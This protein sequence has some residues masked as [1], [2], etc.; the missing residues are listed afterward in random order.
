MWGAKSQPSVVDEALGHGKVFSAEG[1]PKQQDFR[2][3]AFIFLL[4]VLIAV[5]ELFKNRGFFIRILLGWVCWLCL[6]L[7]GRH[8]RPQAVF[9][10]VL[11][12][13]HFE[14]LLWTWNSF[15]GN[16]MEH[17]LC[18][19]SHLNILYHILS[20]YEF[21][22]LCHFPSDDFITFLTAKILN[23]KP[24][25]HPNTIWPLY[26]IIICSTLMHW[27]PTKCMCGP[28]ILVQQ[29]FAHIIILAGI[30]TTW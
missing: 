12:C 30:H 7:W 2:F 13:I 15:F 16:F 1:K 27:F 9:H 23:P 6:C 22:I 29:L 10:L 14:V 19:V 20:H 25:W 17:F 5:L 4:W 3:S 26:Y 28:W 11:I 8:C 21:G 18:L 24:N